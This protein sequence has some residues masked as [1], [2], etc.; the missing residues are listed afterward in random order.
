MAIDFPCPTCGRT[1]RADEQHQERPTRCPACGAEAVIPVVA[2]MIEESIRR[3]PAAVR[4]SGLRTGLDSDPNA[5]PR[6]RAVMERAAVLC[7]ECG[8]DR[9]TG[10]A[11]TTRVRRFERD[12][13]TGV[14]SPGYIV[15]VIVSAV[16]LAAAAA[17]A[18]L[19]FDMHP[20]FFVVGF[21]ATVVG[22]LATVG[23]FNLL[24]LV[25]GKSGRVTL[26][27][28]RYFAFIPLGGKTV[29]LEDCA[30]IQF[31]ETRALEFL[32]GLTFV[33]TFVVGFA[34]YMLTLLA[35]AMLLG[36]WNLAHRLAFPVGCLAGG[37]WYAYQASKVHM[38]LRL[39]G[40]RDRNTVTLCRGTDEVLMREIIEAL[41]EASDLPLTR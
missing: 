31:R 40:K 12:W 27:R 38:T 41:Q 1:L 18:M 6:C 13:N 7:I 4:Y 11:L 28:D 22:A 37:I 10:R 3:E 35:T 30:E 9:R 16:T 19:F 29:A 2:E 33:S 21:V 14:P 17:V 15:G 26:R 20:A 36:S 5:C 32:A 23:T 25:R 24:H 8:F 34:C 39:I